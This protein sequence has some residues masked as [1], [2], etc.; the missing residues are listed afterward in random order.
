MKRL[1]LPALALATILFAGAA[2]RAIPRP[3]YPQADKINPAPGTE[4]EDA[5]FLGMGL[6][7]L[8]ADINFIRL[9][10]YYGRIDETGN[11]EMDP[12]EVK[13]GSAALSPDE[14]KYNEYYMY[15]LTKYALSGFDGGIYRE[16]KSRTLHIIALNPYSTYAPLYSA[17]A[18]AFNLD[19]PDEALDVLFAAKRYLPDEWKYNAYIAAIGYSK[20]KDPRKVADALDKTVGEPDCPALLKQQAAFL[21]KKIGRYARA[22][23]IYE[24]IERT[25]ADPYYVNN[26]KHQIEQLAKPGIKS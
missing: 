14:L 1:V 4:L 23:E 21:N 24:D 12:D 2:S 8:A 13:N 19:R 15:G 9:L 10:Q 20:A 22:L 3:D 6:R 5:A 17:G 18:L 16:M 25:A 11:Y 26:A 7:Q